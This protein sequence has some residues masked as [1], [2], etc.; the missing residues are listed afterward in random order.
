MLMLMVIIHHLSQKLLLPQCGVEFIS[1]RLAQMSGPCLCSLFFFFSGYGLMYSLEK[2]P[3]Y[4]E[5]FMHRMMKITVPY[6]IANVVFLIVFL[7]REWNAGGYNGMY[8]YCSAIICKLIH[9]ELH[10]GTLVTYAWFIDE[11][12]LFYFLFFVCNRFFSRWMAIGIQFCAQIA[13]VCLLAHYHWGGWRYAS[14]LGFIFGQI[15]SLSY[16]RNRDKS[17]WYARALLVVLLSTILLAFLQKYVIHLPLS[18]KG[19]IKAPLC[20]LPV[21]FLLSR[22]KA[23]DVNFFRSISSVS[24][25]T[26]MYQGIS[27]SVFDLLR[28]H[29]PM[30]SC[31]S[32]VF[33][34][35]LYFVCCLAFAI[36]LG[37]L[38]SRIDALAF[39]Y[40]GLK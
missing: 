3:R 26:Y 37:F 25:E 15:F 19:C 24:F 2:K 31:C 1:A 14:I 20:V 39:R 30:A 11:L 16:I 10:G 38:F 9:L 32:T 7:V 23:R 8:G 22:L 33:V 18:D 5:S 36:I 17:F 34:D 12:L 13:V 35:S 29:L 21:V 4:L 28:G 6:I 40:M 27:F